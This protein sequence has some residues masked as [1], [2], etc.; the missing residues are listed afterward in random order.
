MHV[1]MYVYIYVYTAC[2]GLRG[3]SLLESVAALLSLGLTPPFPL[4]TLW[5][6]TVRRKEEGRGM[7]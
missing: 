5:R 7:C 6:V 3:P 2:P 1:C 4:S